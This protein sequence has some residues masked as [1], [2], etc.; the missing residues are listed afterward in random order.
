MLTLNYDSR[1]DVLAIMFTNTSNSI[2][3]DEYDGLVVMRDRKKHNITSI[4]IY[5]FLSKQASQTVPKL[6]DGINIDFDKEVMPFI[7]S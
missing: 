6:P 4:M 7:R 3:T 5:D 1:F 2:G